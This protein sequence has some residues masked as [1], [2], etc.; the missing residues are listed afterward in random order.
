MARRGDGDGRPTAGER[1]P[2]VAD[3]RRRAELE[4]NDVIAGHSLLQ[5]R[6]ERRSRRPVRYDSPAIAR[7]PSPSIQSA[8]KAA[9]QLT[10]VLRCRGYPCPRKRETQEGF[11]I[12]SSGSLRDFFD[13]HKIV[14]MNDLIG[15]FISQQ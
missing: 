2:L 14:A 4:W 13:E 11:H 7:M 3:V 15:N 5:R 9:S 10:K 12:E 8:A 6:S 1:R